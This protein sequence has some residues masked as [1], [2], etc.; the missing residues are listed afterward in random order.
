MSGNRPGQQGAPPPPLTPEMQGRLLSGVSP[1]VSHVTVIH[2]SVSAAEV[3]VIL[4]RSRQ[5]IDPSNNTPLP[6]AMI[7]WFESLSFSPTTAKQIKLSLDHAVTVYETAYGPIP[8]DPAFQLA[9]M[10][11]A[12]PNA[13]R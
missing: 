8:E 6:G 13:E 9:P 5:V 7:E 1:P 3:A 10:P 11:T 4:G 2:V 12:P